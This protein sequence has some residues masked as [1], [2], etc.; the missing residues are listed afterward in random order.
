MTSAT[1]RL[2]QP[3]TACCCQ[4]SGR[5]CQKEED[6]CGDDEE[7]KAENS[8]KKIFAGADILPD[9]GWRHRSLQRTPRKV[10]VA[11]AERLLTHPA[12]LAK[13]S[14]TVELGA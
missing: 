14:A 10:V 1:T 7:K 3:R 2:T 12:R 13:S 6:S 4:V 5:R 11:A 8:G 9:P